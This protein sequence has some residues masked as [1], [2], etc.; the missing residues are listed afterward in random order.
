MP[1]TLLSA[2]LSYD[3]NVGE[4]G[5]CILRSRKEGAVRLTD[6]YEPQV[7]A[8]AEARMRELRTLADQDRMMR[9]V[10]GPRPVRRRI[11]RL[12]VAAGER[13]VR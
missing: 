5:G 12:L 8:V 2:A 3:G 6:W 11:G 4:R 13:L 10:R 7:L 9:E 1:D